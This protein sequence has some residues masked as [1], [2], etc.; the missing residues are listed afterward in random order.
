[1]KKSLLILLTVA[2]LV[3]CGGDKKAIIDGTVTGIADGTNVYLID[4]QKTKVDSTVVTEGKF[5]FEIP[6]GYPNHY[7]LLTDKSKAFPIWVE[8]GTIVVTIDGEVEPVTPVVSGTPTNEA[9]SEFLKGIASFD[10]R[11]QAMIPTLSAMDKDTPAFD[12]LYSVL[13]EIDREKTLFKDSLILKNPNT[14]LAAF[15]VSS[16]SYNLTTPEA[17]DSVLIIVAGAP[18]NPFTEALQKRREL[19]AASAVGQKAPDFSQ[20]QPDGTPLSLSS[21]EGQL[22]LIDFW[23]S[24][25]GPCR[26]ENPNVVKLYDRF[27]DKG[28]EIL[29]VSLDDDR[30]SWL[31][32]IDADGLRWKHISD[33]GGW[34]NVVAKQYAV[35]SIPHTVLVGPDGVIIAKNLR[36]AELEA[37]VAEVLGE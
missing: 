36:G 3:A 22:V 29:G 9:Y 32:A 5:H 20:A 8:P 21:L 2:L 7:G 13:A 25:C 19:L 33:L 15:Y 37:K 26:R 28:F 18:A 14:A 34:G 23:A 4:L 24:W 35:N 10:E 30:D 1:M 31:E 27:H 16:T 11:M 17:V 6:T 12:S